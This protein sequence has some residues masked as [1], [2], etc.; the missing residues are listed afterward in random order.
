MKPYKRHKR[1]ETIAVTFIKYKIATHHKYRKSDSSKI[2]QDKNYSNHCGVIYHN[3]I[4]VKALSVKPKLVKHN[5]RLL[6][7]YSFTILTI[8]T[9]GYSVISNY[10]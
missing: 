2:P 1:H 7:T 10:D 9:V 4:L 6:G 3:Y 5:W 8:T